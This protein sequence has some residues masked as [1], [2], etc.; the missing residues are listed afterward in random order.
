[1]PDNSPGLR[2]EYRS[3]LDPSQ[4]TPELKRLRGILVAVLLVCTASMVVGSLMMMGISSWH[5][6]LQAWQS[7]ASHSRSM[8]ELFGKQGAA[9]DAMALFPLGVP[10]LFGL[11]AWGV[12]AAQKRSYLLV[13]DE[14]IDCRYPLPFGLDRVLGF[15]WRVP[16][17][18]IKQIEYFTHPMQ[19]IAVSLNT[20]CLRIDLGRG[21]VRYV[22]PGNWYRPGQAMLPPV[23]PASPPSRFS[24][25][26][27][28]W[29]EPDNQIRL[30]A[31]ATRLPLITE[32]RARGY[33]LLPP[34][35]TEA[36]SHDL[37]AS[38]NVKRGIVGGLGLVIGAMLLIALRPT[39]HL[40]TLPPGSAIALCAA[41]AG[42]LCFWA[43]GR[44][45]PQPSHAHRLVGGLVLAAGTA[46]A[47]PQATLL[48]NGLASGPYTAQVYEVSK[49]KL[50]PIDAPNLKPILLPGKQSR[51]GFLE[52]GS[53]LTMQIRTG[54]LGLLEYD[55]S[56]LRAEA[57][58][59]G[60][61]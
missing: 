24:S 19:P 42:A 28:T 31:A 30:Y 51:F 57:D 59:L 47:L 4:L 48:L 9:F 13:T 56:A 36:R 46:F 1:M 8:G 16:F 41:L 34:N 39:I 26:F 45:A 60:I 5:D 32:L 3:P 38:R 27:Q 35:P 10:I 7:K 52:E 17:K 61:R 49:G 25:P 15:H 2:L 11:L 33:T 22:R 21:A 53:R 44:E 23:Q 40:Q 29:A 18:R 20:L 58:R 12:V 14:A 43:A 54:R 37:F 55:D 50:L 6:V